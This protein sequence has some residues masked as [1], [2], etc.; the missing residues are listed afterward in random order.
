MSFSTRTRLILTIC[1]IA[2][3]VAAT[4]P[5]F[6]TLMARSGSTPHCEQVVGFF[7]DHLVTPPPALTTAGSVFGSLRGDLKFSLIDET[8]SLTPNVSF[9]DAK[10]SI[11]TEHGSLF[12]DEAGVTDGS[13]GNLTVLQ[14]IT[15]GSGR[16]QGATGQIFESGNFNFSTL[17]GQGVYEGSVCTP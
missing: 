6:V 5:V 14:T 2:L 16:Y 7:E 10:S 13:N 9:Y 15:G 12:I 4:P 17:K 1:A 3:A 11:D 8:A